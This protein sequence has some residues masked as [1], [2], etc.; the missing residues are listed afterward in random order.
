MKLYDLQMRPSSYP[1]DQTNV[2]AL[3]ETFRARTPFFFELRG[4]HPNKMLVGIGAEAGCI[5]YSTVNGE[6][7]YWMARDPSTVDTRRMEF[8]IDETVTEV[9]ARYRL[10]VAML[11]EVIVTFVASNERSTVCSW[12]SL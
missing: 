9:D 3:L 12:E 2:R 6:P 11:I 5:Q 4:D 10:N 1:V 7:P 8:L